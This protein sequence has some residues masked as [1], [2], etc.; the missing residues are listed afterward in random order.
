MPRP[1]AGPARRFSTLPAGICDTSIN[2]CRR[3]YKELLTGL[4]VEND[5]S[6]MQWP[7]LQ[8]WFFSP[9]N[10]HGAVV[11][12]TDFHDAKLIQTQSA[13]TGISVLAD[14]ISPKNPSQRLA[15]SIRNIDP[16]ASIY[17]LVQYFGAVAVCHVS[18]NFSI[19]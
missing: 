8:I 14:Q 13:L 2:Q 11:A 17:R 15:R 10:G 7:P 12:S 9:R 19:W 3:F 4:L 18:N 6:A 16:A 1:S 5:A